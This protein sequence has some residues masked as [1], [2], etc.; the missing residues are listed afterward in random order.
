MFICRFGT[1]YSGFSLYHVD[2]DI[3]DISTNNIWPGGMGQLK[4]NTVLQYETNLKEVESWGH[5]LYKKP[6]E[7][8]EY[9]ERTP[10]ELFWSPEVYLLGLCLAI[11]NSNYVSCLSN[12]ATFMIVDCGGGTVD[13]TTRKLLE[14][15][16]LGEITE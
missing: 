7:K 3:K 1:T 6:S 15:N 11:I 9:N 10:I 4:S 16:Q 12:E 8:S 14:G 5:A 13:L 2:E